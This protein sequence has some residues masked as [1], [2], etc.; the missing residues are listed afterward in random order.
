MK[1][2]DDGREVVRC[3]PVARELKPRREGPRDD[4]FHAM[5]PLMAK[6]ALFDCVSGVREKRREQDQDE[7]KLMFTG[8]RNAHLNAKYEEEE[9]VDLP[10]GFQEIWEACQAEEVVVRDEKSRARMGG[11]LR[12]KTWFRARQSGIDDILPSPVS[13]A[14]RCAWR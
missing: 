9:W 10:D 7:T 8:V 4:L 5:P 2:D 3:R 13:R 6:T 14:C 1:K 11:R 12:G